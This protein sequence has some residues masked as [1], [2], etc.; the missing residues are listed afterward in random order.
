MSDPFA[1]G[2]IRENIYPN[3]HA[4]TKVLHLIYFLLQLRETKIILYSLQHHQCLQK[5]EMSPNDRGTSFHPK[6]A[7]N[8]EACTYVPQA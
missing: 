3:L 6:F 8:I 2:K 5:G 4:R 1:F 7:F